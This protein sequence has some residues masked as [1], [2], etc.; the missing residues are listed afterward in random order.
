M[1][2]AWWMARRGRRLTP[3]V[4]ADEDRA[5]LVRLSKRPTAPHGIAQRARIV[6]LSSE[7]LSN[8]AVA[9]RMAVNHTTVTKWRNRFLHGGLDALADEPRPC[10]PLPFGY[11]A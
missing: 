9:E 3:I 1:A 8:T 7:G 5:I 11:A 4:L 2:Y 6:L 10:A